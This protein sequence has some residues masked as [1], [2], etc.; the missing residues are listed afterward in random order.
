[1]KTLKPMLMIL[2]LLTAAVA[3]H[4][5]DDE[6]ELAWWG[7][8]PGEKPHVQG[9]VANVSATNIALQTPQGLK[10]FTVNAE[11]KVMVR[12][13]KATIADVK[14]GDQAIVRF[15]LV[16]NNVPLALGVMVPKPG[17]GGEIV[18]IQGNVIVVRERARQ[19]RPQPP[20]GN[21]RERR[22]P[23][24]GAARIPNA[25]NAK[26]RPHAAPGNAPAPSP[27]AGVERRII[28]SE[29][30]RFRCRGYQGSIADLRI[31]YRLFANGTVNAN[32]EIIADSVEFVPAVAQGAVVAIDGG[33]ITVKTVKQLNIQCQASDATA[34]LVRPRVGPNQRGTL[35]DVRVGAPVNIGF[36]PSQNR[37]A[38]LLW[39]DV[40]TGQ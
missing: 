34:V 21:A 9:I 19:E 3:V 23:A 5:A 38:P 13:Q 14:T 32:G 40:L 39:V 8:A 4:A 25:P 37:P 7:R 27:G 20:P 36:H 33:V 1:M 30:T 26:A 35:A 16:D 18:A 17:G 28:V 2:L 31:G 29:N 22:Q 11:T 6:S 24:P 10:P 15:R 12:G